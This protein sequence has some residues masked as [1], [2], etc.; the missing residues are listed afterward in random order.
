MKNQL[1]TNI[2]TIFIAFTLLSCSK[3]DNETP[4]ESR[5]IKYEVTGNYAG[6]ISVV[7]TT[8]NDNFEIIEIKKLPWKL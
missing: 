3:I 5:A 6:V 7:V 4:T 1:K 8:N 2:L